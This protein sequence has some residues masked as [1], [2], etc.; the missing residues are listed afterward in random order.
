MGKDPAGA[1]ADDIK[2]AADLLRAIRPDIKRFSASVIDELARGE[3]CL[4]AGNGGDLNMAKARAEEVGNGVKVEVLT[5]PGMGFWIESWLIPADAKNVENAH[6]YINWT[7][8]ADIAARNG[9]FVTFAPASLP[10]R[11]KMEP[12]LVATR[13][14][15]PNAEDMKNGFVMPQMSDD[16]KRLSV[17]LWQ[18]ISVG[19]K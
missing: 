1:S 10:A 12:A 2:A 17:R 8:D 4:T 5:P 3:V 16:A 7:L 15:F 11:E 14:I 9:N 19:S 18:E 6:K 13:S